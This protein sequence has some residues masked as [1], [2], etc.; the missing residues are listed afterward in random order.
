MKKRIFLHNIWFRLTAPIFYGFVVYL[1]VLLFFDSL[2]N[3][4]ENFLGDELL[5]TIILTILFFQV[6]H[7]SSLGCERYLDSDSNT[8][9]R[10]GFQLFFSILFVFL[11]TS[12]VLYVYFRYFLEY[13]LFTREL[14]IFNIIFGIS[15]IFY[16]LIYFSIYLLH[17]ENE[18]AIQNEEREKQLI[19]DEIVSYKNDL[20]SDFFFGGFESMLSLLHKDK[21]KAEKFLNLFSEVYRYILDA[22]KTELANLDKEIGHFNNVKEILNQRYNNNIKVEI[23]K[24]TECKF[25]Q[26]VPCSLQIILEYITSANIISQT[27]PLSIRIIISDNELA[28]E[29]KEFLKLNST[30][31][32]TD[33]KLLSRKNHYYTNRS[34][35]IEKTDSMII[36]K[37]PVLNEERIDALIED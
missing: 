7:L 17:Y 1:L 2:K 21:V 32:D 14:I 6:L 18:N 37:V 19:L 34:I 12:L 26:I 23:Q 5:L 25:C 9:R 4:S 13:T 15:A 3:L 33:V 36:I 29:Y 35:T 16:N 24:K 22:K 31:D 28:I 30:Y 11:T 20:R 10:I 27:S 8:I